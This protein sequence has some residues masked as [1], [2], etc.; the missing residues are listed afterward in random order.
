M[1]KIFNFIKNTNKG[2]S[3]AEIIIGLAIAGI[4]IGVA[5]SAT[6]LFLR[7]GSDLRTTQAADLLVQEY[8]DV[9]SVIAES[10]WHKIYCPP[11][12]TC[13]GVQKGQS[14]RFNLSFNGPVFAIVGGSTSTTIDNRSF[15]RYFSIENVNRDSCGFGNITDNVATTCSNEQGASYIKEDPS[16]QKITVAIQ[17]EGNKN[18]NK[19]LYLTRKKNIIS[20]QTNWSGGNNQTGPVDYFN[21]KFFSSNKIDSATSGSIT[22]EDF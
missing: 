14:S 13:P 6:S 2:Q 20:T 21:D 11:D 19:V 17:W 4:L 1:R 8:L 12:G 7:Q 9:L 5:S 16:T 10:D 3:L 22:I 18:F 15:T